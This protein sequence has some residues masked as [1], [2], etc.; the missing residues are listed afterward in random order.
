M[1]YKTLFSIMTKSEGEAALAA[2]AALDAAIALARREDAHLEVLALGVDQ[3]QIGYFYAGASAMIYQET[4][5]R[6]QIDAREVDEAV[7]KRLAVEDIRWSTEKAVAQIGGMSG[8]VAQR[9]R[10]ADLVILPRPYGAGR[11]PADEAALEAAMFEG[12][13]PVLVMPDGQTEPPRCDRVVVAWN[14]ASEALVAIRRALPILRS[15]SMVNIA[16]I[17]PP[18]HGPERSDPGGMLSQWL[19]RHGVRS[20]VSVLARTMPRISDVLAR[21]IRDIDADLLVMGAYGHSR[22]REA[23]LG[24]ATR[25]MLELADV[26]V[27]LAH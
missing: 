18:Q 26:P 3:T 6:A 22:F 13:A 1:S 9:A 20:E 23:I 7:R 5:E 19:A 21:H 14:Q 24:G 25:N 10:F 16:I 4:I 17:D 2:Q 11:G 8:L 15:A 27:L 12:Q